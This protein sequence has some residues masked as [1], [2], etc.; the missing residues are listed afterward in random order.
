MHI[1]P[2]KRIL[3]QEILDFHIEVK[4]LRVVKL[5]I[6]APD[7]I[8]NVV[9]I[10]GFSDST[11]LYGIDGHHFLVAQQIKVA[12]VNCPDLHLRVGLEGA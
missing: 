10:P 4:Q 3:G 7:V 1:E 9:G 11:T 8:D 5:V 6:F 2:D 12:A